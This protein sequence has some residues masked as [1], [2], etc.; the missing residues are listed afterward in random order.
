MDNASRMTHGLDSGGCQ[1]I[2]GGIGHLNRAKALISQLIRG[3]GVPNLFSGKG[4][5]GSASVLRKHRVNFMF[6]ST[7]ATG[8]DFLF[9][10]ISFD[11]HC[12]IKEP[13][14]LCKPFWQCE[15]V[16]GSVAQLDR[17]S[18]YGCEGLGFE[19]LQSHNNK[20]SFTHNVGLFLYQRLKFL[21]Q[22]MPLCL[23]GMRDCFIVVR[24]P[25][26][27]LRMKWVIR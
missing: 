2:Y 3:W 1:L 7:L 24:W 20:K 23:Q 21:V 25:L 5:G 11:L 19:S 14:Y 12:S 22:K 16:Y 27:G 15:N 13:E 10:P 6:T 18:H 26:R 4:P 8:A 17:A 9:L